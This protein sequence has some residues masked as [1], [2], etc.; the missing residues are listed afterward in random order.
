MSRKKLSEVCVY[1]GSKDSITDEHVFPR[2]WFPKPRPDNLNLITVPAC[3]SCNASFAKDQEYFRA[4]ICLEQ[5][6][7]DHPAA[8]ALSATIFRS[9]ERTRA[10]GFRRQFLGEVGPVDVVSP[11]G[12]YLGQELGYDVDYTRLNR[13]AA[14]V[15]QGLHY[16]ER[17]CR[18]P[19]GYSVRSV[20]TR[21]LIGLD[22]KKQNELSTVLDEL[23]RHR[24]VHIGEGIA[25]Y[26]YAPRS[27]DSNASVWALL[28]YEAVSFLGFV[29]P[30]ANPL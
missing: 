16:Y 30:T 29:D 6:A 3:K 9:L 19:D 28:M 12:V 24:H 14:L 27:D 18:V 10:V 17:R 26:C 20:C 4:M 2:M 8:A 1:C 5:T 7:G 15:F 13:G 11:G 21:E 25:S 23:M 22:V